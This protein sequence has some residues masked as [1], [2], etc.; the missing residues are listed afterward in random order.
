ML[1]IASLKPSIVLQ[2]MVT[3]LLKSKDDPNFVV[4]METFGSIE[5]KLCYGCCATLALAEM[6][7]EGRS[8]SE[9]MLGHFS[10]QSNRSDFAYAHL[11]DVL[12]FKPSS[13]QD[14]L[15]IGDLKKLERAVDFARLGEVLALIK[16]LTGDFDE[17]FDGRW[18]LNDEDWEEQIPIIKATIAEMAAAG[19]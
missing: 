9:L 4:K 19:Y 5:N 3:G 14:S 10:T 15:P 1:G 11:P 7:G 12:Q 16:F 6:F 2:A 13:T 18:K 17:S 8:A